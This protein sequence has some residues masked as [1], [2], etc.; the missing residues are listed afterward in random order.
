MQ[1]NTILWKISS[2][3][4]IVSVLLF[5]LCIGIVAVRVAS[6]PLSRV[7]IQDGSTQSCFVKSF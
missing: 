5:M 1:V 6:K 3:C 4:V 2:V 7:A